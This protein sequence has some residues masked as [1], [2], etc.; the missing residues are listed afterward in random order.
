MSQES[1]IYIDLVFLY[2]M[3]KTV[4]LF[5]SIDEKHVKQLVAASIIFPLVNSSLL[6]PFYLYQ[7]NSH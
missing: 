4:Y 1:I 2:T 3:Y 5:E 7:P 6:A